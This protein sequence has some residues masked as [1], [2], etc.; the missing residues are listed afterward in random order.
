MCDSFKEKEESR[1]LRFAALLSKKTWACEVEAVGITIVYWLRSHAQV[2]KR[3]L[4]SSMFN[5]K[6]CGGV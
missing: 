2:P 1:D 5:L 3:W 4:R 6:K